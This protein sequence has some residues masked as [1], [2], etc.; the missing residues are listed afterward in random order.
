LQGLVLAAWPLAAWAAPTSATAPVVVTV[1]GDSITAGLGLPEALALPAQLEA[2]LK[3]HGV[4]ATVR[5]AGVS[6][7]TTAGGL[8]RLDFSVQADTRVCV[9]ELGANDFLQAADLGEIERNLTAICTR[10]KARRIKAVLAGGKLPTRIGG[11]YGEAFAAI[12]PRVARK[13]GATLAPDLLAG[14]FERADLRQADALHPSGAG[15]RIV[16]DRLADA[17]ARALKTRN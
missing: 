8:A 7:D 13:T 1:L 15:V 17:V 9:V 3:R 4:V 14:L 6:G 10:L 16:A 12:F 2:A 5:G 11:P